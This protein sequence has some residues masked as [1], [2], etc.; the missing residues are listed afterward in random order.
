MIEIYVWLAVLVFSIVA[1]A[2]SSALIA[3]WF[4]PSALV[5]IALAYFGVPLGAQITVF[6]LLSAVLMLLFYKKL[7]DNIANKTEKTNLDALI[8]ATGVVE[9]DISPLAVGRVKV[10]GISWSAY[11]REGQRTVKRGEYVRI[12]EINGVKLLCSPVETPKEQSYVFSNN[13]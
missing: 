7:K 13:K 8:G 4:A 3:I 9:E 12:D 5:C 10:G 1:E 2:A 11:C 6:I